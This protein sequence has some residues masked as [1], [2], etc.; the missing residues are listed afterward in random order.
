MLLDAIPNLEITVSP[1]ILL[2]SEVPNRIKPPSGVP[3]IPADFRPMPVAAGKFPKFNS[4]TVFMSPAT[5]LQM[6]G[7]AKSHFQIEI[8]SQ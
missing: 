6:G 2:A 3:S 7:L 5:L 4:T 8:V 1:R